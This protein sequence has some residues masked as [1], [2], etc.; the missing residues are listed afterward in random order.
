MQA[1]IGYAATK[2]PSGEG[3]RGAPG[4]LRKGTQIDASLKTPN[5]IAVTIPLF[6]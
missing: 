5:W 6:L 2:F 4:W 3:W 1:T